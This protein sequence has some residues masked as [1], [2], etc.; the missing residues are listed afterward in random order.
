MALRNT[1]ALAKTNP[2]PEPQKSLCHWDF[3]IKEAKWLAVDF[4]QVLQPS[5]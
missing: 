1:L 5:L 2:L 3:V 4:S